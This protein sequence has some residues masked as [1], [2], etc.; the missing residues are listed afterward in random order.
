[1]RFGEIWFDYNFSGLFLG[2]EGEFLKNFIT[3]PIQSNALT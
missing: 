2:Q 3:N 1:M